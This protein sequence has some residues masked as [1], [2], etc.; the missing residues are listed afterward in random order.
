LRMKFRHSGFIDHLLKIIAI[1]LLIPIGLTGYLYYLLHSTE[2][3]LIDSQ[4]QAMEK[5]MTYLDD[6]LHGTYDE[7]IKNVGAGDIPQRDQAKALNKILQPII[8]EAKRKYPNLDIGY[9]WKDYDV[10]LDGNNIHL[11]ENFST[12]RKNNF[13]DALSNK[14]IVFQVF[15]GI[16]E[17]GQLEAYQPIIRDDK[18]I[19]A[20]WASS[21]FVTISQKIDNMKQVVYTIISVGFFLTIF[22]TFSLIRKFAGSVNEIKNNLNTISNDPTFIIPRAP[23][24]LGEITDAINQMY[25][26]LID[27]Q[28]YNQEILTSIDDGIITVNKEQ[29]IVSA[30]VAACQMLGFGKDPLGQ[31]MHDVFREDS[32]FKECLYNTLFQNKPVKDI[33]VT[34][35]DLA[36]NPRHL[37]I[38]TSLM[39]NVRQD[40]GGA[41][42]HF[43]D[44]TELIHLREDKNRQERFASLGKIIAG[45]AHEI[46][47]PLTSITGYMQFWN[48]GHMPTQKSLNIINREMTRLSNITEELLQ[49]ARPSRATL[50]PYEI[51]S[52]VNRLVQFFGDAHGDKVELV[53]SLEEELPL[54][55]IDQNQIEKVLWNIMYNAFQSIEGKGKLETT[56]F[57]DKTKNMVGISIKDNG[58]GMTEG[59]LSKIFEPFFTTKMKGTGLGLAIARE[60]LE[61]HKGEY[62][63]ESKV[64]VGTV[65]KVFLPIAERGEINGESTCY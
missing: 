31:S 57:Y 43:R 18:I 41:L 24:E 51:N 58:C 59:N 7:I 27:V 37:L 29:K 45:V 63:V 13:D 50:L 6:N 48:Q 56:T 49:F 47:S 26:K 61:S 38:S 5:A 19:G 55:M 40:L 30:N 11:R 21:D 42:L 60:I 17:N 36:D 53:T 62:E 44:I 46:R 1:L 65:I 23:G 2:L 3:G 12:R 9:Y 4:R 34:Y 15:G 52:L 14:S 25:N 54:V 28:N 10:I 33:Q 8:M 22:G 64:N 35:K 16:S 20:I 32:P 39:V